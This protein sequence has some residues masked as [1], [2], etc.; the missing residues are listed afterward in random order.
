MFLYNNFSAGMGTNEVN[1][2]IIYAVVLILTCP[3]T[4]IIIVNIGVLDIFTKLNEVSE[5]SNMVSFN[6]T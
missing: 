1:A 2:C 4:R 3:G 6:C 5:S